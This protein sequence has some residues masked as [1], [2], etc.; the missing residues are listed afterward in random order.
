MIN[1]LKAG[2]IAALVLGILVLV[3]LGFLNWSLFFKKEA[4]S[5]LSPTLPKEVIVTPT[6]ALTTPGEETSPDLDQSATTCPTSCLKAIEEATSGLEAANSTT[7]P[8]TNQPA[9][10]EIYI[11][12]GSGSTMSQDW[13]EMAGVEAVVDS[14]NYPNVKEIIFEAVLKIPSANGKVYAKLYDVNNKHDVWFSEVNSEG[15]IAYRAESAPIS[16][17]SGR[18]LYRVKMKTSMG[19]EAVLDSARIKI[20]LN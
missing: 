9:V 17:S 3:N 13:V 14:A 2:K 20:V 8:S 6:E 12:L 4:T 18:N 10:K 7:Q 1:W 15:P 11:P 16:L 5:T 19:Y